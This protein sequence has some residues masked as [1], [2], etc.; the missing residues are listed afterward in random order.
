MGWVTAHCLVVT[1]LCNLVETSFAACGARLASRLSLLLG[2]AYTISHEEI[3]TNRCRRQVREKENF[4]VEQRR[5]R[6]E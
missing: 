6:S 2:V 4:T 5:A 1:Y 3:W